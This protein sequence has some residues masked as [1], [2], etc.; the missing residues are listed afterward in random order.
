MN[1]QNKTKKKRGGARPNAGR[2]KADYET[3][4]VSFRVKTDLVAG[5]K[6]LAKE[7]ISKHTKTN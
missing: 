1:T 2:K 6:A 7:Y 4:V 3:E 5:L